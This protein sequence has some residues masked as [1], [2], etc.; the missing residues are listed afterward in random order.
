MFEN[1]TQLSRQLNF[2]NS[3]GD[4]SAVSYVDASPGWTYWQSA[5]IGYP[6]VSG[7]YTAYT[8]ELNNYINFTVPQ[9]S[10]QFYFTSTASNTQY[11]ISAYDQYGQVVQRF[12][13]YAPFS[14]I[15]VRFTYNGIFSIKVTGN[16]T[17]NQNFAIDN[18]RFE[19]ATLLMIHSLSHPAIISPTN[20]ETL[21]KIPSIS[22][23]PAVDSFHHY[24]FYNVSLYDENMTFV[25]NLLTSNPSTN[26]NFNTTLVPN[27]N[28]YIK[29]TAF[30][31]N[32]LIA[33]SKIIEVVVNNPLPKTTTTTPTNTISTTT[34]ATSNKNTLKT[35]PGF[36]VL[37]FSMSTILL[38][39]FTYNRRR[40]K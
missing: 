3:N 19:N 10:V 37:M 20:G 16:S 4:F 35:S 1:A 27:G 13:F 17:W 38:T 24:I 12:T 11:N 34:S 26:V 22:W 9:Q 23:T 39:L 40:N 14:N 8:N 32:G 6:P 5:G 18:F 33:S 30:D 15:A 28:Y 29:V 25:K 36:E 7:I 2:E 31:Y 21:S